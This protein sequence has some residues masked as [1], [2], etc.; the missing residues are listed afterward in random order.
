MKEVTC[1]KCGETLPMS[2]TYLV[3]G[4][5]MCESCMTSDLAGRD[6]KSI[7]EGSIRKQIDPTVCVKCGLDNG[8]IG[9]RTLS[10]GLP[11]CPECEKKIA[12]M[13]LPFWI[14]AGLFALLL[15]A[16]ASCLYNLRFFRGYAEV[17]RAVKSFQAMETETGAA[18]ME[19]AAQNVPEA[20]EIRYLANLFRGIDLLT[21]NKSSEALERFKAAAEYDSTSGD[22]KEYLLAAEQGAAFDNRDY[23]RFLDISRQALADDPENFMA[24]AGVASA[25]ACKWA[26]TGDAGFKKEAYELLARARELAGAENPSFTEYE[27]RI[28]YRID[29]RRIIEKAEYDVLFPEGY[30][31]KGDGT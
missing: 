12:D 9:F 1:R 14:K 3:F 15:L 21:R 29:S 24:A 5:P 8:R 22:I 25:L 31:R 7:P 23:D 17:N 20:Q 13:R 16:A 11:V 6:K 28:L 4:A 27:G 18:L 30:R 26:V 10:S 19:S 2:S